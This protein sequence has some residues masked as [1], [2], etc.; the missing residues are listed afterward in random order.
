[1]D[2]TFEDYLN[3]PNIKNIIRSISNRFPYIDED[4]KSSIGMTTLW[5]CVDKYDNKKG[6]K[7]TSYLYQQLTYAFKNEL[8]KKRPE[9][10]IDNIEI[11][12]SEKEKERILEAA[13][14]KLESFDLLSGLPDQ[15]RSI[16]QQ[17]Y[18]SNMTMA[19]IANENGYSRETAR[20]RLKKAILT[21]RKMNR[22]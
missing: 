1:M 15:C 13:E 6:T 12:T 3:D 14:A 22:I 18:F 16:L 10:A 20:R 8:K 4:E 2:K 7:F 17:R 19:E 11:A 9:F 21:C 5:K